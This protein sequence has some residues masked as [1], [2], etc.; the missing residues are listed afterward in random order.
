MMT[1]IDFEDENISNPYHFYK[2]HFVR[3]FDIQE[4]EDLIKLFRS[5]GQTVFNLFVEHENMKIHIIDFNY[6]VFVKDPLLKYYKLPTFK[7]EFFNKSSSYIYN[8]YC[9]FLLQIIDELNEII[10]LLEL[11]K[12]IYQ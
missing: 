7:D 10:K 9:F 2:D 12:N 6:I 8:K 4:V 3:L 1:D 11:R 5:V